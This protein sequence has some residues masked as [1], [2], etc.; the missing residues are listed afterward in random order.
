M[1]VSSRNPPDELTFVDLH[2]RKKEPKKIK[3]V[4]LTKFQRIVHSPAFKWFVAFIAISIFV[5]IIVY[6]VVYDVQL[7]VVIE[8]E[9]CLVENGFRVPCGVVNIS[10]DA[11]NR[12]RCCFDILTDECFH[13]LPS[14]YNYGGS[15]DSSSPSEDETPYEED[16]LKNLKISVFEQDENRLQITIHDPS[17]THETNKLDSKNYQ[18]DIK[19]D[20]VFIEV[21][22][23]DEK[24]R[25]LTTEFGPLIASKTYWEWTVDL[26]P[27]YLYGLSQLLIP[28]NETITKV[29]YKN[30]VDAFTTPRFMS[31][32][33]SNFHGLTVDN[34]GP[35][36]VIVT[37]GQL[38]VLRSLSGSRITLNLVLGPTPKDVRSQLLSDSPKVLPPYWT[39]GPHI[40]R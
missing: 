33:Q 24:T 39:L 6:Y 29:I 26:N 21:R 7:D 35:L 23:K 18:V 32:S 13:Y 8:T 15:V 5:P 31:Y 2:M 9:T 34:D 11:C 38:V 14:K 12:V 28:Y 36:E 30:K 40:C 37:K 17:E 20:P 3:A 1:S 16:M 25:V 4:Q 22:R 10:S 19:S 27:E